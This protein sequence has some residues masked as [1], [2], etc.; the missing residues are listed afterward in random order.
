MHFCSSFIQCI[1]KIFH[2][3]NISYPAERTR[4]CAYQRTRSVSFS[5]KL[6]V[7]T[8]YVLK[9]WC[10]QTDPPPQCYRIL[11]CIEIKW[12][13]HLKWV[14]IVGDKTKAWITKQILKE[15]KARQ[16]SRKK[17]IFYP[18]IRT[19]TCAYQVVKKFIFRKIWHALFSCS[20]RLE[21]NHFA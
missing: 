19:H 4:T 13:I 3:T 18:L 9:R 16:I 5:G 21:I 17:N 14:E 11:E 10:S 8:A 2:K 20:T 12:N 1:H 6:C 7:C 15:N